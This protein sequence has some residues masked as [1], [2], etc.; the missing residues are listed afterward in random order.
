MNRGHSSLHPITRQEGHDTR[1]VGSPHERCHN[2]IQPYQHIAASPRP[3]ALTSFRTHH[4]ANRSRHLTSC[5][6]SIILI[7]GATSGYNLAPRF[8]NLRSLCDSLHRRKLIIL[9]F[10]YSRFTGRRFTSSTRATSFY[11]LGCNIAFPV[12]TGISIGNTSTRPLF[13]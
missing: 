2:R 1:K 8:R 7:I 13:N 10:P 11:R 4:V 6:N 5:L 12:F 9:N 3:A